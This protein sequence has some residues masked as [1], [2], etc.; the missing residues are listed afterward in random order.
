VHALLGGNGSGK[1]TII[2]ILAGVYSADAGNLS[3]FGT[4]HPLSSYTS[5]TAQNAGLRFVHQDLGL[6]E[7]LSIAENF[8]LDAGYPRVAG[9]PI[10]WREL[11]ARVATVLAD[12]ELDVDPRVPIRELRPSDRTMVAIARALQD[13]EGTGVILVLDEPTASLALHESELLLNKVR[14][15]AARGQTVLIVS[16][17]LQE[18]LSA[19]DDFTIFRDGRVVG[20]LVDASPTEDELVEI[21]AGGLVSALRPT[22]ATSHS[23]GEV[24]LE[25]TGLVGGPLHGVNLTVHR[26]EIVGVAGLVGSGRSTLL[27]AIFGAFTPSSGEVR[28]GGSPFSASHIDQAMD[29]GIAMVPEDRGRE[30]AFADLSVSENLAV[31]VLRENWGSKWMPRGKERNAALALIER[32]RVKVGGPDALFSSMS[33]GNQQKSI[34]ARWLQRTPRLILLDEPTQGVDVM[35]RSDIYA[36][37]REAASSGCAVL[38]ASS[39]MSELHALCDR[40]VFLRSGRIGAEVSAVGLEVDDLMRMV[41]KDPTVSIS[42]PRLD[43]TKA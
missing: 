2:K 22:G 41:L 36:L 32:F 4:D 12:Y 18:V 40:I 26:G 8:A 34:L 14:R 5:T 30:A 27:K 1:S 13:Q 31:S 10:N 21:M 42:L 33:G 39:D 9:G 15:R 16:H 3:I 43:E 23:T 37:I 20:Q 7:E 19:A 11:Y 35:S 38:V 17:R 29:A 24:L 25:V 28:L 6:F